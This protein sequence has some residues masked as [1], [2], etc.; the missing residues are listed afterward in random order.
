MRVLI[1]TQAVDRSDPT[2]GF[3]HTWIENLARVCD[4]VTVVCL[5]EGEYALPSNVRVYS[6]GK[7]ASRLTYLRRFYLYI[8]SLLGDYDAVFVHMNQEYV[9]LGGVL[10]RLLGKR[11]VLWRN[12][13]KGSFLTNVAVGLSH[14]VCH[15]SREA[16]VARFAKA[17]RMP[18]GIDTGFFTPGNP[19]KEDSILFLGRLDAVKKPDVF[20]DAIMILR[21][22]SV[23]TPVHV[24]GNPT[25]GRE[26][27]A[28][29]LKNHF[30]SMT[31][32]TFEIGVGHADTADIYRSHSIYVNLTPSGSFDKTIGEALASG[33]IVVAGN[34]A[35][36]GVLPGTLIV[37]PNSA[38]SVAKGIQ[39][40]LDFGAEE[41]S[42]LRSKTR[43]YV[44]KEHSLTLLVSKLAK[45]FST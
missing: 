41:R 37:D 11:I 23:A 3:F 21:G 17:V 13:K 25:P 34:E 31:N 24:Y 12:H 29:K 10:W 33:C 35:L 42:A 43:E 18:I 38:E 36:R 1:C 30:S 5:K 9:L 4:R 27:F 14:V 6:L 40:A 20:L 32:L 8:T 16:Y 45:L 2:L 19:P 44:E 28:D 22:H 15:T 26:F 39:A 7:P